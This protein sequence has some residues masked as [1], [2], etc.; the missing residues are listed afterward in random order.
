MHRFKLTQMI[1]FI[2]E[3]DMNLY[4]TKDRKQC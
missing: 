4:E 1:Y 2:K 3:G